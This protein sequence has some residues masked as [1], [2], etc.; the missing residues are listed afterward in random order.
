MFTEPI[1]K[2]KKSRGFFLLEFLIALFVFTIF[3]GIF[4][5]NF[6]NYQSWLNKINSQLAFEEQYSIFRIQLEEDFFTAELNTPTQLDGLINDFKLEV[7]QWD[8]S[9]LTFILKNIYYNYKSSTKEMRKKQTTNANF[10]SILQGVSEFDYQVITTSQNL[11]CLKLGIKSVF[12]NKFRR[13][14]ICRN[15]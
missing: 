5:T 6:N 11:I 3:L 15:P 13:D 9:N 8:Y 14:S 2:Q 1:K 4:L 12:E 10:T 7:W